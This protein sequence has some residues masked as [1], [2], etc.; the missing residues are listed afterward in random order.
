LGESVKAV[1]VLREGETAAPAEI[2]GWSREHLASY[3]QTDVAWE[4]SGEAMPDPLG[5]IPG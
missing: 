3:I 4:H 2:V 5:S 1:I